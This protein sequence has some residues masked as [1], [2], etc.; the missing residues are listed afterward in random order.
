AISVPGRKATRVARG[1]QLPRSGGMFG[2]S[3]R[4]KVAALNA[5]G[6]MQQAEALALGRRAQAG[7]RRVPGGGRRAAQ[8]D[9]GRG[10]GVPAPRPGEFDAERSGQRDLE[11]EGADLARE[12]EEL[13]REAADLGQQLRAVEQAAVAAGIEREASLA[14]LHELEGLV[15]QC[16]ED[17]S[18]ASAI[19]ERMAAELLDG[20]DPADRQRLQAAQ[21]AHEALRLEVEA[22]TKACEQALAERDRAK[23]ALV[24]VQDQVDDLRL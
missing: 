11:A 8:R 5:Q 20:Q 2:A 16:H 12:A 17:V 4:K 3:S 19:A 24:S 1:R 14:E 9:S 21:D 7:D 18:A 10:G 6:G 22:I 13:R 15:R 23:E